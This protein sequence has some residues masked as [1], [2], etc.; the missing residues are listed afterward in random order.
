MLVLC[1]YL[2]CVVLANFVF[3]LV[4][5]LSSLLKIVSLFL[6]SPVEI[7]SL[8]LLLLLVVKY[9]VG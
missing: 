6:L 4:I 5:S 7:S 1:C 3:V 9:V 8:E 2:Y